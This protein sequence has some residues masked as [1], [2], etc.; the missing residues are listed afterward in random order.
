MEYQPHEV[1]AL[2]QKMLKAAGEQNP[3]NL[4]K[5]LLLCIQLVDATARP[6]KAGQVPNIT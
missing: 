1:A 2:A 3:V 4:M 5:A 6:T